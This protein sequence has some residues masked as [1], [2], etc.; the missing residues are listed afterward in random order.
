[1]ITNSYH[2]VIFS[3]IFRKRFIAVPVEGSYKEM[4][5]RIFTLLGQLGLQ[6]FIMDR[7]DE[8]LINSILTYVVDWEM[9]ENK[10]DSLRD[11]AWIFLKKY[12]E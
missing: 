9:V 4:N 3:I 7:C 10:I 5:D 2:G 6:D 8:N 12:F 1:M 11:A